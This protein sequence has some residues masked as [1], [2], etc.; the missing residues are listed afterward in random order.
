MKEEKPLKNRF[1]FQEFSSLFH[2]DFF[3]ASF[4]RWEAEGIKCR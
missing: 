1:I 4:Q 3:I 2:L